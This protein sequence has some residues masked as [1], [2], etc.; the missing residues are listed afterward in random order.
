M[1]APSFT[2]LADDSE[3]GLCNVVNFVE[4][5]QD[6]GMEFRLGVYRSFTVPYDV[7][8]WALRP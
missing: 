2:C 1:H 8:N 4:F 6:C 7:G 5:C 3:L